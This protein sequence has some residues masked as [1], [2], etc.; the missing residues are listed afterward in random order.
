[1]ADLNGF[2]YVGE[3]EEITIRRLIRFLGDDPNREGLKDTPARVIRAY[4]EMF[5]GYGWDE[6]PSLLAELCKTFEDGTCD[7]M[8]ILK[9]IS[10]Y[11]TCEHH[12]LPFIG[13]AH[14]GYLPDKRIIGLS[15]LARLLEVFSRRLQ[16]Q[17]RLT[18]QVTATLDKYLAPRG[19]ACVIEAQHLCLACRG[20]KKPGAT[21]I[22][23]SLTGVF[24]D[25]PTTRAEFLQFVKG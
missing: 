10:F 20:A 4:Q 17:E 25:D 14:I 24:R 18:Q 9:D 7:E 8:V 21:M 6:D 5:S 19:S 12:M 16:V 2:G 3:E 15:K 11:S 1:M 22:T 13:I 23:S